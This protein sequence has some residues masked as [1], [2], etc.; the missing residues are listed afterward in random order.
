MAFNLGKMENA[1]VVMQRNVIYAQKTTSHNF[2]HTKSIAPTCK[3]HASNAYHDVELH[4]VSLLF[5]T[6]HRS[7]YYT[8]SFEFTATDTR[9]AG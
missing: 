1:D 5:R 8:F 3:P 9:L 2:N 6:L 4:Y 7:C